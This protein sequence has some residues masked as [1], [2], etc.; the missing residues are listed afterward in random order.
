MFTIADEATYGRW[1][2]KFAYELW[3]KLELLNPLD[4]T[5]LWRGVGY[6]P[7]HKIG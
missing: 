1:E 7:N 5:E 3:D 6:V 2:Y 4:T